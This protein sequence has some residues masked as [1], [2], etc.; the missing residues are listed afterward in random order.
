MLKEFCL[1]LSFITLLSCKTSNQ[2][3][4]KQDPKIASPDITGIWTSGETENATFQIDKDSIF[5]VDALQRFKYLIVSD[6]LI[7]R[8]EDNDYKCKIAKATKDSL[9]W[10]KDG[11][12]T[13]FWRFSN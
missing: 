12:K 5:Y 9:V 1:T 11:N 8:F 6:S 3:D 7:I 2:V 4:Q 10:I 13:V